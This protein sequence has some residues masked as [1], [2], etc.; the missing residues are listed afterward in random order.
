MASLPRDVLPTLGTAEDGEMFLPL[1]LA[2]TARTN[3]GKE[4]FNVIAKLKRGFG[5]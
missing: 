2:E 4:D 1:P 5:P 3:R